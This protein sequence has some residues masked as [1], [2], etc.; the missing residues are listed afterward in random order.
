MSGKKVTVDMSDI[1]EEIREKVKEMQGQIW[2]R[3]DEIQALFQAAGVENDDIT[4]MALLTHVHTVMARGRAAVL[5]QLER[6]GEIEKVRE[7]EGML[8]GI[9]LEDFKKGG[10]H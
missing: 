3:H 8:K 10:V 5:V 6:M 1:G 2:K 4:M 9:L 7:G